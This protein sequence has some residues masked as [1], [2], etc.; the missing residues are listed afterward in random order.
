MNYE[1]RPPRRGLLPN[2]SSEIISNIARI[3]YSVFTK[4]DCS[5]AWRVF[6]NIEFWPKFCKLYKRAR[7][8]GAPW[9]PGSRVKLEL[10][11]P[12]NATAD[13]VVTVCTPPH[14]VAWINHVCGYT[15]EQWI[16]FDPYGLGGTRVSAWIE[17]TGGDPS[18]DRAE[19][20]QLLR[21]VVEEWFDNFWR[22]CDRVA[23]QATSGDIRRQAD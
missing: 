4:A 3:E 6:S 11:A 12:V 13:R 1:P 18:R 14:H 8:L 2:L 7:W 15:M 10:G 5:L 19:D 17:V 23:Q 9:T 20:M 16:A 22:E 21:N